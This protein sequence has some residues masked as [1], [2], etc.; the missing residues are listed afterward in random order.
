MRK[1]GIAD[2]ETSL[3]LKFFLYKV[4]CRPILYYGVENLKL[5]KNDEKK[6]QSTEATLIK[7]A[8]KLS[9]TSRTTKLI[10]AMNLEPATHRIEHIKLNFFKRVLKNEFTAELTEKL[11]ASFHSNNEK[12]MS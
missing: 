7:Y 9:K 5:M 6:I 8:L 4:Y 3:R 11:I 1:V 2:K 10:L 12:R